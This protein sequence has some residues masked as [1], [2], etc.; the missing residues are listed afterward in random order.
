MN[1][2]AFAFSAFLSVGSANAATGWVDVTENFLDLFGLIDRAYMRVE[3][4]TVRE[5]VDVILPFRPMTEDEKRLALAEHGRIP[6]STVAPTYGGTFTFKFINGTKTYTASGATIGEIKNS[7]AMCPSDICTATIVQSGG[8]SYSAATGSGYVGAVARNMSIASVSVAPNFYN[9]KHYLQLQITIGGYTSWLNADVS[10]VTC[11]PGYSLNATSGKCDLVDANT[12]AYS[13]GDG[14]C[15]TYAGDPVADDPD[16]TAVKA[17]NKLT[18]STTSAGEPAISVRSNKGPVVTQVVKPDNSSV[19]SKVTALPDGGTQRQDLSVSSTGALGSTDVANYPAN[20]PPLYPGD[21]GGTAIPG[22]S[23]NST[24]AVPCGA[25]GQ[26]SCS[27]SVGELGTTNSVLNQIKS[28]QCGGPG[29]PACSVKFGDSDGTGSPVDGV[30]DGVPAAVTDKLGG[31]SDS[32][33]IIPVSSYCPANMFGFT[34]PL[35]ATMGGDYYLSDNGLVC[36]TLGQYQD[37]I[38]MLS[39]A[40]GFIASTFIVLRA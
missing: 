28:G 25:P 6:P 31:L 38:R 19:V 8:T 35:P 22:S 2:L 34:L 9:S 37:V 7:I 1:R 17:E 32:A 13:V 14:V 23:G 20:P 30:G 18:T 33:G 15:M 11:Q 36:D 29:Q 26:P 39:I 24:T 27:V 12:A 4:D 3:A 5:K 21:S 10:S 16:C 40:C